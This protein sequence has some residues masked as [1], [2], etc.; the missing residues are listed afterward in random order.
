MVQAERSPEKGEGAGG[1]MDRDESAPPG[2]ATIAALR[3]ELTQAWTDGQNKQLRF[4][5][6]PVELTV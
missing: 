5:V 6:A 4:R 3:A 2:A 1:V